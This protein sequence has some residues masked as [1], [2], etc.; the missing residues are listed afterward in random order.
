MTDHEKLKHASRLINEVL[1]E[2]DTSYSPCECCS[3]K[4]YTNIED[5][6]RSQALRSALTRV[7]RVKEELRT[8]SSVAS[9]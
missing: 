3:I 8:G 7:D 5:M 4:R 1:G 6:R 9:L 2:L